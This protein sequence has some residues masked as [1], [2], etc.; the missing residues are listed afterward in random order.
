MSSFNPTKHS[1]LLLKITHENY[2]KYCTDIHIPVESNLGFDLFAGIYFYAGTVDY[3]DYVC[4]SDEEF[5]QL[6][7]LHYLEN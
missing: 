2:E 7:F 4:S 5:D 1:H 3:G 6:I